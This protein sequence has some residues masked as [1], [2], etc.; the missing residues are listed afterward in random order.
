[1][2]NG[3]IKKIISNVISLSLVAGLI[4]SGSITS[5]AKEEYYSPYT[6][7]FYDMTGVRHRG[8]D[9]YESYYASEEEA[10]K[11]IKKLQ[12]MGML[13]EYVSNVESPL[14][15]ISENA[16]VVDWSKAPCSKP[17]V[18][19]YTDGRTGNGWTSGDSNYDYSIELYAPGYNYYYNYYSD[20]LLENG[21]ITQV[22]N[23]VELCPSSGKWES[24][25]DT[26]SI[27][28]TNIFHGPAGTNLSFY[29]KIVGNPVRVQHVA[30]YI[31]IENVKIDQVNDEFGNFHMY[32]D[33]INDGKRTVFKYVG[34]DV[35]IC[36]ES[37]KAKKTSN[38][39]SKS[40]SKKS[41]KK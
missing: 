2:K 37:S 7:C 22:R 10:R 18:P 32:P 6:D 33:G 39:K 12:D 21:M 17:N 8:N 20:T 3:V 29:G 19:R 25:C 38:S 23:C 15:E 31:I 36:K 30:N 35:Y 5:Y 14:P 13:E 26:A 24:I 9:E 16:P 11:S 41:K 28:I 34:N 1:M 40:K 4:L 27:L